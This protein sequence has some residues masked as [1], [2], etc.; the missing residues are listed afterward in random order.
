MEIRIKT[1][2]EFWRDKVSIEIS[3]TAAEV[4]T[5]GQRLVRGREPG[6]W[7]DACEAA[8]KRVQELEQQLAAAQ[9]AREIE[10][11]R[12]D[13]VTRE[14]SGCDGR[15]ALREAD[16]ET[17]RTQRDALE[18]ELKRVRQ[19][20]G[21]R[22]TE[23]EVDNAKEGARADERARLDREVILPANTKLSQV[24]AAVLGTELAREIKEYEQAHAAGLMTGALREVRRV[25]GVTSV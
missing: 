20:M 9:H 25:M 1:A 4:Q 18:A 6:Y 12:A 5:V 10:T 15:V 7:A 19:E 13:R 16:A 11:K 17:W 22:F 14:H 2:E 24:H 23:A 3:G 21:R 8:D